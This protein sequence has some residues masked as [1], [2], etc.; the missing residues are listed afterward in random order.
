MQVLF[1][2]FH[3]PDVFDAFRISLTFLETKEYG[4]NISL[5]MMNIALARWGKNPL[6]QRRNN[7]WQI[8]FYI[9][10]YALIVFKIYF[11]SSFDIWFYTRF[12]N[13]M[14]WNLLYYVFM[15]S[16]NISLPWGKCECLCKKCF[17]HLAC[18]LYWNLFYSHFVLP[19]YLLL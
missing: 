6:L 3:N 5:M 4:P 9:R 7:I 14:T 11:G 12:C 10:N 8:L 2:L 19:Q 15:P 1:S 13:T 17:T 16:K 18:K